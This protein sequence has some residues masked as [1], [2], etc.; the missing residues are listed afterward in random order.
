MNRRNVRPTSRPRQGF[1]LVE[2]MVSVVL[3]LLLLLGINTIFKMS[4]DTVGLG[5]AINEKSRL[6]RSIESILSNDGP[7][8]PKD[9]PL[10][11]IHM[12]PASITGNFLN[13][14]DRAR[15]ADGDV[16][17]I[18]HDS[19]PTT[20][21]LRTTIADI[22]DR[23]HR[24]D[25]LAYPVRGLQRRRTANVAEFASTVRSFEAWV[26]MGHLHNRL[27]MPDQATT[28]VSNGQPIVDPLLSPTN[29][30]ATPPVASPSSPLYAQNWTV[31]RVSVMLRHARLID[32]D[33][34]RQRHYPRGTQPP[35]GPPDL[36]P[37][38]F[39][40]L[41]DDDNTRRPSSKY[42]NRTQ[43]EFV[44]EEIQGA[45]YDL[46]SVTLAD[47]RS[48]V[49]EL[50][51]W[52]EN[53]NNNAEHDLDARHR[54]GHTH[55]VWQD[56]IYRF[57]YRPTMRRDIAQADANGEGLSHEMAKVAPIM[58]D[59]ISQ[60]II[61]FAGDFLTQHNRLDAEGNEDNQY[62]LVK[63][64]KPD[65]ITDFYVENVG[66]P[67]EVR[68]I[69]WY[70]MPRD[71]DGDGKIVGGRPGMNNNSLRDV[72]PLRD[73]VRTIPTSSEAA[74]PPPGVN[75]WQTFAGANFERQL[76]RP[77]SDYK[78]I[79]AAEEADFRYTCIWT[80]ETPRMVRI[81]MKAE[82]ANGRLRDG[83]WW[84]FVLQP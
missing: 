72:V 1:T 38:G 40:S 19:D 44:N 51:F 64:L 69:R 75:N 50:K 4:S 82:D 65:G 24:A 42:N 58:A 9:S 73:I 66:T 5:S 3:V 43:P 53:N 34:R 71:I 18:D 45:R 57:E 70:G 33:P 12:M 56:L 78:A 14:A 36:T 74:N 80:G 47:I 54:T 23:R 76:P 17:T 63:D 27:E 25:L 41:V 2:L 8:I 61:E 60:M 20:P 77:R 39:G 6:H 15:D 7:H 35:S 21:E 11:V 22:N 48:Y 83:Q 16:A 26:W 67:Q 84:E 37:I 30:N 59:N 68:K 81:L 52:V 49:N 13:E 79:T 31:G 46:A 28:H 32:E 55:P 10:F 62:G 29:S